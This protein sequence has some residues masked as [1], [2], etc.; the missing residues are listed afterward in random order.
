VVAPKPRLRTGRHANV[1]CFLL[2]KAEL[3][4]EST[5]VESTVEFSL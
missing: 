5:V 4:V 3:G 2:D 1:G